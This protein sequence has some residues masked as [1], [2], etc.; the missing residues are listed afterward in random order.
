MSV[1]VNPLLWRDQL[2]INGQWRAAASG[3]RFA[4][5]NPSTGDTLAEV[6]D[7][8]ADDAVAAVEAAAA[9]LP[10]WQ[11]LTA[12]KRS[13]LLRG[14]FDLVMQ[15][16]ED[17]ARILTLEQGKPLKEAAGEIAYGASYIEW[18][19]EEAKRIYGDVIAPPAAD[20]RIV[21]LKQGV[22]VV[23]AITPWNFP[24]AM[25]ARKIAP[26]LAA[27]CTLVAKPAAQ[28]PLSAL[29]LAALAEEAG[30]P[31]GVINIVTGT[32]AAAIGEVLTTHP[33]VRKVTFTGSTAVGKKLIAQTA[34][35][36]KKVTMELGGNA[37]FIVF[38]DADLD[39]AVDGAVVSKFRNAGQTCVCAN[40][41]Y[42]HAS[43]YDAFAKKLQVAT[44]A[45]RVGDGLQQDVTLGPLINEA[46]V[47]KVEDLV[48]DAV[49][50]GAKIVTGG[51][52]LSSGSLFYLPT[53]LV[54]V[55][56]DARLAAEEIF[57]PVA[58]LIRFTNEAEVAEWANASEFGLAAY[59]YTQNQA[60]IWRFS[61]RLET[62]MV[63]VNDGALSNEM[64]P[65]GG[66]KQSG[67]GREG[68]RYGINDYLNIKYLAI[69]GIHP[70]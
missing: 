59:F 40:R 15:H 14:W 39:A 69:G 70:D 33:L 60:R 31:A 8:S 5:D 21:T 23:T 11:A 36:V 46:A 35:S 44:E 19:A 22:G 43:V 32:D 53:L 18:F 30:I 55:P 49:A 37:P 64:A 48:A 41:F 13:Q 52:R 51:Q 45:L 7:A 17:L 20:K 29:A 58:A 28:T 63:A 65:F 67:M 50:R 42:V 25:L 56:P 27:G 10:G 3:A 16:Q 9:A 1:T 62:G 12:K 26:A 68:S 34:D 24:N 6:A 61:E 54:D 57:G 2:Y 38:D 4:V 66:I 47:K